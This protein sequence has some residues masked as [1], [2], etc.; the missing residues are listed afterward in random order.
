MQLDNKTVGRL[1]LPAGRTDAIFFDDELA[2]FGLRLR[3]SGDRVRRS[4]VVQYRAK[5]RTRRLLI[6]SAEK[7]TPDVARKAARKE[8]A[9]VELG[10]DPQGDKQAAR[11][12]AV[13]TLRSMVETYLEAK[14]PEL[15]P[16]SFYVTRLYLT[17]PYFK[18]LHT[19]SLA[20]VTHP[21]VAARISAIERAHGAVTARQ[22]RIALGSFYKWCM[23]EGLMGTAPFNPVVGTRKPAGSKPR[24][25]VLCDNELVAIWHACGNDDYGWI[26]RLLTLLGSRRSEVGGM[27]RSELDLEAGTWLLPAA[28]SKNK[29]PLLVPLPPLALAI[30]KAVP[31]WANRDCLFGDRADGGFTNWSFCKH[32]LDARLGG[33]VTSWRLHDLR[34]T[35]A[36]KMGDLGVLPHV[37][38][39]A[40]NH[41]SGAKR[42]IAGIY[43][44]SPYQREVQTALALWAEHVMA[45]V[46]GRED[47]VIPMRA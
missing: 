40:L 8:L 16:S 2:G 47:K 4:W 35:C 13:H 3:A 15:R 39:A 23:T 43:N 21:D 30:I 34:R 5:G 36:T 20:A 32:E 6:G 11:R 12:Q 26:V 18:P 44:K 28:R 38:E 27:R 33:A 19:T 29:H 17:G 14:K 1:E 7:L 22:A 25:R 37:V 45:L 10:G 31:Q 24:E 41:Q 46:E 9:K 42:G